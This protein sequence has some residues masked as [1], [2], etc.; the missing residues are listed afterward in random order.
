V[1]FDTDFFANVGKKDAVYSPW[2]TPVYSN[3]GYAILGFVVEAVTGQ[4]YQAYMQQ[5]VFKPLK[6]THTSVSAP[7]AKFGFI[8]VGSNWWDTPFGAD[9]RL[10]TLQLLQ[11]YLETTP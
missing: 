9:I 2:T 5:H 11:S 8:P 4:T 1:C 3:D 6:L 10:V 7:D